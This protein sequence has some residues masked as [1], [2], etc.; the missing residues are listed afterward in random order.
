[1][2]SLTRDAWVEV[3]KSIALK[4]F[5]NIKDRVKKFNS[6]TKICAVVKAN[7]YG[8]GSNEMARLYIESG[9]DYLAVAT[10]KEALELRLVFWDVNILVLGYVPV[11]KYYLAMENEITLT[12]FNY[13]HQAKKLQEVAKYLDRKAKIHVK[14]ETGMNRIGFT[15]NDESIE[16]ITDIY[17]MENIELEGIFTHF[18]KADHAVKD[19]TFRQA[20]KF[21]EFID[22]LSE[23]GVDIPIKHCANSAAIIDM[24]EYLYDMCRPGIILTG[25]YPS[26][27]VCKQ[28]LQI[29]PCIALKAKIIDLKDINP[30]EGV[31]YGH[32]FVAQKLTKVA[33]IPLGYADGFD[34]VL[35][36]KFYG[37]VKGEKSY[38]IGNICMDQM[39]F[40]VSNVD[41]VKLGDEIILFG[42]NDDGSLS[43]DDLA[44]RAGT[45]SYE[46]TSTLSPRLE[47]VYK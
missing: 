37:I 22:I 40:D 24:P 32:R 15:L 21:N 44:D 9:V 36:N 2:K 25:Y 5:E 47:R 43:A 26:Y 16:A 45:I 7:S 19:M 39:M 29:N 18:A 20:K 10:L 35:S 41:D 33:T 46:I 23:R 27:E 1:M 11:D 3:D 6:S 17:N 12:I 28:N 34:R 42:Y 14:V 31:G 4:N 8:M 38:Q 30:G 13:Q